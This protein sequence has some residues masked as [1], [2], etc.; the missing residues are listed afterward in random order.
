MAKENFNSELAAQLTRITGQEFDATMSQ[1]EVL[2]L[3]ESVEP[4]TNEALTSLVDQLS[5]RIDALE[6]GTN[7]SAEPGTSAGQEGI[8][9]E[10]DNQSGVEGG[11]EG[12]RGAEEGETALQSMQNQINQLVTSVTALTKLIKTNAQNNV[13]NPSKKS[14]QTLNRSFNRSTSSDDDAKFQ[15]VAEK[16]K[17]DLRKN[18]TV[19]SEPWLQ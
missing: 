15:A 1:E 11:A 17:E 9:A 8:S 2:D 10:P 4:S 19:I 3:L 14:M 18:M 13:S 6:A 12:N 5:D 16:V 7:Q